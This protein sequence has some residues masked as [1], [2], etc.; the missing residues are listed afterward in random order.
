[1]PAIEIRISSPC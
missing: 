1:M